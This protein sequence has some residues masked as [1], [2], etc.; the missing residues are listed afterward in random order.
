MSNLMSG[1][2]L[3]MLAIFTLLSIIVNAVQI[4]LRKKAKLYALCRVSVFIPLTSIIIR[5]LS[6]MSQALVA[7]TKANDMTPTVANMGFARLAAS[8]SWGLLI[9]LVLYIFYAVTETICENQ[10]D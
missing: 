5:A 1:E 3:A 6:G 2:T 9:T 4:S 8:I 10:T 7:I